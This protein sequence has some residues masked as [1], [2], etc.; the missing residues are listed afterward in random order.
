VYLNFYTNFK[1][2]SAYTGDVHNKYEQI[3]RR[4]DGIY[5]TL[6]IKPEQIE[7]QRK[8]GILKACSMKDNLI[9]EIIKWQGRYF[10]KGEDGTPKKFLNI[11]GF[12]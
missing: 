4:K 2:I 1:P 7:Y 6:G 8:V 3:N 10:I 11:P 5:K 12:L 9:N